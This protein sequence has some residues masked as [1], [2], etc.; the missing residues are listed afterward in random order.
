MKVQFS[1]NDWMLRRK[2]VGGGLTKAIWEL[3][4]SHLCSSLLTLK[5]LRSI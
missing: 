3:L 2:I 4:D 1:P 5:Y